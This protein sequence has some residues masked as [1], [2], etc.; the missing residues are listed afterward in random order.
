MQ[1]DSGV[2]VAI[3]HLPKSSTIKVDR[4]GQ[5][6]FDCGKYTLP[7]VLPAGL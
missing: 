5:F 7:P 4:L 1:K 3:F 6:H 2:Y